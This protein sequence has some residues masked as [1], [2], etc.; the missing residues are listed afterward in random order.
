M[1]KEEIQVIFDKIKAGVK[2]AI[3]EVYEDAR[4]NGTELVISKNQGGVQWIKV[5]P[6]VS[7]SE[8]RKERK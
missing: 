2:E 5:N 3:A 8:V 1:T 4:K 7:I 6:D